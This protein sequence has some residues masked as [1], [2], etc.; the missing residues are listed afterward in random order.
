[1]GYEW[2]RPS[3]DIPKNGRDVLFVTRRKGTLDSGTYNDG[4]FK[5]E[6]GYGWADDT[7]ICWTYA[8]MLP[9]WAIDE[10]EGGNV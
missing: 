10:L 8:P 4:W 7:V 1:M 3:E 5:D 6:R 2:E 9:D